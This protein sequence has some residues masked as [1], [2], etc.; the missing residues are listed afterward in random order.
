MSSQIRV[1][2][3]NGVRTIAFARPEKKNALTVAMYQTVAAALQAAEHDPAIKVVLFT[4]DGDSFTAGNDL[5]DFLN[6]PPSGPDSPV[7]VVL[8]MLCSMRKPLVAAVPGL[9]IGIGTTMLLHCDLVYA[10]TAAKFRMPFVDLGLVPEAASSLLL[11]M[12]IGHA[13]AAEMLLLGAGFDA[14]RA[15]EL[16]IV[17]A[18]LPPEQLLAFGRERAEALAS[19]P[20]EALLATKA[21]MKATHEPTLARMQ[22]EA[23][24]FIERLQS[25]ESRA[26]FA[27][28]LAKK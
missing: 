18:V 19:K 2:D 15:L 22:R 23:A 20:T 6:T 27:N 24:L 11:P 26:L 8:Q 5:G 1:D 9:A 12:R 21:L 16:G 17:H 28:F 3:H 4:G 13:R 10:S 14:A 7:F 25:A